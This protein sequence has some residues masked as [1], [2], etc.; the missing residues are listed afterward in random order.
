MRLAAI[1]AE[2]DR[3]AAEAAIAQQIE[4][5]RLAAQQAEADRLEAIRIEQERLA[6]ER[7]CRF[8]LAFYGSTPSYRVTLDVHGWEGLQPELNR[9]SKEG[10]WDEMGGLID[11]DVLRTIC[12][13]G[14]PAELAA[15]LRARF[16]GVADRVAFSIP[17][18]VRREL[19]AE[20]IERL[21]AS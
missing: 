10:R 9:L 4:E 8:N 7:G 12:V 11:D 15:Q 18:G 6:A 19:L 13:C 5:E 1:K 21:R 17:Y 3:L 2:E 20:V 16:T 14:T